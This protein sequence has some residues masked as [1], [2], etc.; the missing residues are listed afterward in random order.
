MIL[1]ETE[2][3]NRKYIILRIV[4]I[5]TPLILMTIL[6]FIFAGTLQ[7]IYGWLYFGGY[8][9]M[10]LI[11]FIVIRKYPEVA[12][13]R[14]K[15]HE[16][17]AGFDKIYGILTAVFYFGMIILGGLDFRFKLTTISIIFTIISYPL[18]WLF[19]LGFSLA[20]RE[21]RH[22]ERYVRIQEERGHQVV[23]TG[24]YRIVRHPGYIGM[25]LQNL[26]FPFMIGSVYVYIPVIIVIILTIW[27]TAREDVFLQK[28]LPGY[29]EYTQKTRYRL[30]PGIW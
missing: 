10:L 15:K 20:M 3:S 7:W 6:G 28:N 9:V 13:E 8:L 14:A 12:V 5:V 24:P 17:V 18:Y 25:I 19:S 30:I 22:F 2:K 27:R 23:Q 16:K 4:Q 26:V 1:M 11:S 29:R 21:N